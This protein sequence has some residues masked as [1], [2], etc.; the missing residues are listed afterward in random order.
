MCFFYGAFGL[1]A[2]LHYSSFIINFV[3]DLLI[4]EIFV[5]MW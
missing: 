1:A 2:F 4:L 3:V 5:Q